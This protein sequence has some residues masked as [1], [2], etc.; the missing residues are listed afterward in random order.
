[1]LKSVS[2]SEPATVPVENGS[3]LQAMID[4]NPTLRKLPKHLRQF[5]VDQNYVAYTPVDHAVWRYVLRQSHR[6]FIDHAHQIYFVGMEKTGLKIE[7]IPSIE[8]M[9]E[10]L[11]KIGWAAVT[12][13]GFIPPSAFMEFQQNRVLV[14]ASDM[15][16]I[17]HIEYTPSPDI[18]HE[19]AGHAPVIA[20]PK[21]AEYLRLFGEVGA[22]ALS[23]KKDYELYEAIRKLSILKE[24]PG[25]DQKEIDAAEKDVLNKQKNLGKPSEMAIL[26]RLHWWT[27][28]YGLIGPLDNPKIYGA[29]LLSSIGESMTCLRDAIKKIPYDISASDYAFD[30]TSKQPQLFITPDFRTLIDVLEQFADTMSFRVGGPVGIQKAIESENTATAVYSSGM[31]V[32][33]RFTDMIKDEQNH[34]IYLITTGRSNLSFDHRELEGHGTDYHKDGFSSPIGK[35]KGISV[36]LEDLSEEALSELKIVEH[37]PATLEFDSGIKVI[38]MC[39][40]IERKN[41]KI[42]LISFTDCQ[43][44]YRDQTLFD[45]SW[46]VFDMAVGEKIVSVFSGAA[47]KDAYHQP[48]TVSKTRV[49][50]VKYDERRKA[51]HLLYQKIRDL[52][53]K[54]GDTSVILETWESLKKDHPEDWL[55]SVEILEILKEKQIHPDIEGEITN[56]L[57]HKAQG[58]K[59]LFRLI[60]D[61]IYLAH[62]PLQDH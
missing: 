26:S 25:T 37:F 35:L 59:T 51:L 23:S 21:Y 17:H 52:R 54:G 40:T 1:M 8:E 27:V 15:R 6:F 18:I 20:D 3:G 34:P 33:G 28:E 39:K 44:T 45:P 30:I 62:H 9:N 22:K 7:R 61:G 50:K 31:Q 42:I 24:I 29:G 4:K 2:L 5:I 13:D 48:S 19:A 56:E 55:L 12:V 16:Q 60:N 10:V 32:S 57:N 49:I 36:P 14:I 47:D 46:G 58:N 53:E 41:N 43:V 38:G 11:M